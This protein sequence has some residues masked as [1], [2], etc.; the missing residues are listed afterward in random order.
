[1]IGVIRAAADLQDFCRAAGWRFCFIGGL[2]VQRWAEPR[3][4]RDVDVILLTG[5]GPEDDH[6]RTLLARYSPRI[7]DAMDF[8]RANR[9]L[10]LEAP[11]GIGLDISLGAIPF[12]ESAVTRSR[13]EKM[14][15]G[16][17]LQVCSP[18]DLIVLKAFAGRPIDWHDVK[19][20][21]ARQGAGKLDWSYIEGQ[22]AP[23]CEVKGEPETVDRLKELRAEVDGRGGKR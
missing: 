8:A 14:A 9:V 15:P 7:A 23:L 18:E 21:I 17:R 19:M 5:F 3:L 4:T 22:L 12:E 2:A 16:I 11:G 13:P 6:I 10:L 20:T 1:M